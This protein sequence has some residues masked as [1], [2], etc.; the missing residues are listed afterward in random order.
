MSVVRANRVAAIAT[1][2]AV[3]LAI[4]FLRL[5]GIPI[6]IGAGVVYLGTLAMLWPLRQRRQ[7]RRVVLPKEIRKRDFERVDKALGDAGALLRDHARLGSPREARM[8]HD[9]ADLVM[10][11]RDHL[12]GNPAHL[13]A[14]KRFIRHGLARLIQMV[15]DYTDLKQRALP[16]HATRLSAVLEQ[17][18]EIL[19]A[20]RR[21]DRACIE[22]D[23]SALE[24]SVDVMAEQ[25][26]RSRF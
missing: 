15:T 5:R 22:N 18:E 23:L 20:L 6:L 4:G 12:H 10:R 1:G 21:I 7:P 13:P 11:I 16:E 3:A 2:V 19:P 26:G 25:A 14:I 8:F 24:I 9:A 17:M